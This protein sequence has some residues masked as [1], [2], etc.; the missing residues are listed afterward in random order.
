MRDSSRHK[1]AWR[2]KLTVNVGGRVERRRPRRRGDLPEGEVGELEGARAHGQRRRGVIRG[3]S[4][5]RLDLRLDLRFDL[6]LHAGEDDSD[7]G[8]VV[9]GDLVGLGEA[10]GLDDAPGE[11]VDLEALQE[12][13]LVADGALPEAAALLAVGLQVG[14]EVEALQVFALGA[15]GGQRHPPE[16]QRTPQRDLRRDKETP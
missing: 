4:R 1:K 14:L 6:R 3:H 16:R 13:V 9:D 7:V 8:G 11:L 15:A 2:Y 12:E 10:L 5:L